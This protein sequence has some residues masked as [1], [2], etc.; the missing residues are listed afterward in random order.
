MEIRLLGEFEKSRF[1]NK[2]AYIARDFY[3]EWE[4]WVVTFRPMLP[5]DTP[6]ANGEGYDDTWAVTKLRGREIV[7]AVPPDEFRED[8]LA[9]E[10]AH[11]LEFIIGDLIHEAEGFLD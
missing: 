9:Q 7:I 10:I 8:S 4:A 3:P 1:W 2:A 6:P 5:D 11:R